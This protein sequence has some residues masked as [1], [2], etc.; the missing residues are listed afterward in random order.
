MGL[1]KLNSVYPDLESICFQHLIR[2]YKVI[3]WFQNLLSNATCTTTSSAYDTDGGGSTSSRGGWSDFTPVGSQAG[4]EG[5]GSLWN[6]DAVGQ[7]CTSV[8]NP[9]YA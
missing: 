5:R 7:C 9:V 3:S 4:S 1:Y 6:S 8:F 2:T